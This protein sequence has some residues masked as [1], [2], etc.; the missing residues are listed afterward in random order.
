[1]STN[2]PRSSIE[3]FGDNSSQ[4]GYCKTGESITFGGLSSNLLVEDYDMLMQR[5]WS[6]S[7]KEESLVLS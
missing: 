1:M 7:G 6:R 4:C 5:G 3:L 2:Q